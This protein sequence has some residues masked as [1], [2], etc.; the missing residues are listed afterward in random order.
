M[1]PRRQ[2]RELHLDEV[3]IVLKRVEVAADLG[4]AWRSDSLL[5]VHPLGVAG[6]G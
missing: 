1:Q 5:F 3:E 2:M 6:D 4:S